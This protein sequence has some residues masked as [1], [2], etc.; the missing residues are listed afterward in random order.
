M[1]P[2]WLWPREKR[3]G[4][5]PGVRA[6]RVLHWASVACAT[7]VFAFFIMLATAISY[8]DGRE[9]SGA[10]GVGAGAAIALMLIGRGLR[11]IMS[12]E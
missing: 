5:S 8:S 12:D 11:Y 2:N 10:V 3:Q 1:L 6:G 9:A 4:S 7:I